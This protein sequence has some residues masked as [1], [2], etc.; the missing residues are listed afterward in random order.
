MD[1]VIMPEK[2]ECRKC[3]RSKHVS[4]FPRPTR[5]NPQPNRT[6]RSCT[7]AASRLA[8]HRDPRTRPTF[9]ERF[10]SN[11]DTSGSGGCWVWTASTSNFGYG[12][13]G[14]ARGKYKLSHRVSWEMSNGPIPRGMFVCHRCDNPPC[15][16]PDHLFLGTN[17]ITLPTRCARGATGYALARSPPCPS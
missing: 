14:V 16:N 6:C 1:D 7:N 8:Y 15:V 10:W 13:F 12:A 4:L 11:V 2:R 9:E 3:G 5:T 17:R